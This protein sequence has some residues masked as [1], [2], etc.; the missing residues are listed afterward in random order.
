MSSGGDKQVIG[1]RYFAGLQVVLGTCI[2]QLLN[3]NPDNR[4]WLFT[5]KDDIAALKAG[6]GSMNISR[7]DIFGG[8]KAEG[9]WDG[10]IDIHTGNPI[11]L[12]Q[13][14]YLAA[15]TQG[16]LSSYPLLSYLVYRGEDVID[17]ES[18]E[19][20]SM[21]GMLKE[22]LYMPKRTDIRPDGTNQWHPTKAAIGS[23]I[24]PDNVVQT[25]LDEYSQEVFTF[26]QRDNETYSNT[27]SSGSI[28]DWSEPAAH[29]GATKNYQFINNVGNTWNNQNDTNKFYGT[30][31]IEFSI[32]FHDQEQRNKIMIEYSTD[33]TGDYAYVPKMG[34]KG[35]DNSRK[36]IIVDASFTDGSVY[37]HRYYI[38]YNGSASV[39]IYVQCK[40]HLMSSGL[41]SNRLIT[42]AYTVYYPDYIEEV[43]E[44]QAL[45]INPI[46]KIREILTDFTAM[47]K[48]ESMVNDTNFTAAA[49]RIFGEGLGISWAITEKTCKDAI[50]ELLFHIEAG[51]R[52]NRQTGLYEVV[53]FRDDLLDLPNAK[54]FD[55]SNIKSFNMD[56]ANLDGA[57]NSVNVSYYDRH[58]IKDSTF[59]LY[60]L[61]PIMNRELISENIDFPYYMNRFNAAKVGYW[62]L[63]QLSYPLR[64]GEFSTGLYDARTINR[65]DVLKLSWANQGLVNLPVRV[66]KISLG[67]GLNN[68]VTI[69]WK[70][71][72]NFSSLLYT[73][74]NRDESEVEIYPPVKCEY[75]A[76]EATY[77][78]A[79]QSFGHTSTDAELTANNDLGYVMAAAGKPQSNSMN[80]L[81]YTDNAGL[82]ALEKAAVVNYCPF[83]IVSQEIGFMDTII[84]V[85]EAH[86]IN[87]SNSGYL[88]ICNDEIMIFSSYDSVNS[89]VTI[90]RGALDTHPQ[91]HASGSIIFVFG[92]QATYDPQQYNVNDVVKSQVLTT[93]P[94]GVQE[95]MPFDYVDVEMKSRMIKPYPPMDI[96][97]N[98]E[99]FPTEIAD[100]ADIILT[101]VERNRLTQTGTDILSW[102]DATIAKETGVTYSAELLCEGASLLITT[103]ITTLTHTFDSS[104][105]TAN[106][107]HVVKLWSVR[108]GYDN[109]QTFTHEFDVV[110]HDITLTANIIPTQVSGATAASASMTVVVDTS[111]TAN[112]AADGESISGTAPANSTIT[113]E[114]T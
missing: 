91:K 28:T 113:I 52:V 84:S 70:E 82:T 97:I 58:N 6:N 36:P 73:P 62:K 94:S 18:F 102:T 33:G 9:G 57:V 83:A 89:T 74:P 29:V 13:N 69:H 99:Y 37:H 2:D 96:K 63:K 23:R 67:D 90:E 111:L 1:Y 42:P 39:T 76:F 101:W 25:D 87:V 4:G 51:I 48:P 77:Y 108:D 16:K 65:Y 56:S 100:N 41:Y 86:D 106:K 14:Q 68:T 59:S 112:I 81:L 71:I 5:S 98:S 88:A 61:A 85:S 50:D 80:A 3:I 78:S 12:A 44:Q 15:H 38:Y 95:S 35:L 72:I 10:V 109:Y 93:T 19:L 17:G 53:L 64:Q 8:D 79:V 54:S 31:T 7:G 34:V 104:L 30:T 27:Y 21:S 75:T 107:P 43:Y 32:R 11:G 47:N 46:H 24:L 60:M 20:V 92:V 45:D 114:V 66:T 105:L 49:D 26:E 40:P 22:V 103:G 55:E 110:M